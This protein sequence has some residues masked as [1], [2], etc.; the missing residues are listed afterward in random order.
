MIA[1][2]SDTGIRM[3]EAVGIMAEDVVLDNKTP[4]IIIRP[5][6]KRRLKTKQSERTIPLVG[7]SLWAAT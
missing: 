7:S 5:N 3:A 2:I 4:H 1:L 6:A